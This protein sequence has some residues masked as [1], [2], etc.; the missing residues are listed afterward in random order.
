LE[1]TLF[2]V[3]SWI[4]LFREINFK[5]IV[6]FYHCAVVA[7]LAQGDHSQD[8][9]KFPDISPTAVE[10]LRTLSVAHI[11]AWCMYYSVICSNKCQQVP[12]WMDTKLKSTVIHNNIKWNMLKGT[13]LLYALDYKAFIF[14]KKFSVTRCFTDLP[15][16]CHAAPTI[17]I[18]LPADMTD[19][20]INMLSSSFKCSHKTYFYKRCPHLQFVSLNW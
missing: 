10:F 7:L 17:W 1:I 15:N 20:F 16:S 6:S 12:K 19:N 2:L 13:I 11:T 8:T 14:Y 3:A 5:K 9:V 4:N 18:S